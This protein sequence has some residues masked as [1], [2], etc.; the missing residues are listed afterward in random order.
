MHSRKG[1]GSAVALLLATCLPLTATTAS[2]AA[3]MRPADILVL[4]DSQL[5]FGSG[6]AI[7]GFLDD[8]QANCAGAVPARDRRAAIDIMSVGVLGVRATGLHMWLS[9]TRKG[10]RMI[11]VRDPNGL[12]NASTYGAMRYG[13]SRWAQIGESPHHQFCGQSRS[14]LENIFAELPAPARLVVFNFLGL[15]TFRWLAADKLRQDLQ[16]LDRQLP[17]QTA[18]LFLTTIPTYRASINRPRWRAQAKLEAALKETGSRCRV[19]AGHTPAT[20]AAFENNRAYYHTRSDGSVRDPYHANDAGARRFLKLRGNAICRG[21]VQ[22]L[23][24]AT[25]AP[26]VAHLEP[27]FS[28]EPPPLPMPT[29]SLTAAGRALL[30]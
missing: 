17:K 1:V 12:S 11:C 7:H 20:I 24:P 4:G 21:V 9:R 6:P 8:F 15:S 5:A 28:P 18:C 3:G 16:E 2:L 19:V 13:A 27:E 14:P 26:A 29:V 25:P 10:T 30:D 22:A 23:F